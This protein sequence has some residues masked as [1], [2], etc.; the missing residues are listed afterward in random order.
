M[1][2]SDQNIRLNKRFKKIFPYIYP[3]ISTI[4]SSHKQ[5]SETK[6]HI[7]KTHTHCDSGTKTNRLMLFRE[8]SGESSGIFRNAECNSV[9]TLTH[10]STPRC[11]IM[12]EERK[13]RSHGSGSLHHDIIF[14]YSKQSTKHTNT[15]CYN[16]HNHLM[17]K[18]VVHKVTTVLWIFNKPNAIAWP[19]W[20]DHRFVQLIVKVVAL[21]VV[22]TS[23]H[24]GETWHHIFRTKEW[25]IYKYEQSCT[26]F[27]LQ[28]KPLIVADKKNQLDVTFCIL[29]FSSNSCS[30]CF[31][32]PCAHHQELTTAW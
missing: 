18:Q 25:W 26:W 7:T 31:G 9:P 13:S 16:M 22:D 17:L 11:E 12:P 19:A 10:Y 2:S 8:I 1:L 6:T 24:F 29:Y 3:R 4:L 32:Q 21:N 5:Y 14:I 15:L 23:R 30:T 20:S 27:S 28:L